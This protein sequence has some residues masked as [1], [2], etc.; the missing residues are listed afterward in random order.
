LKGYRKQTKG[1]RDFMEHSVL[2]QHTS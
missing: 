2:W 1:G